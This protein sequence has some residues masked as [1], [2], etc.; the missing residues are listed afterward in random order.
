MKYKFFLTKE[1]KKDFKTLLKKYKSLAKDIKELQKEFKTNPNIGESLGDG[2]RKIRLNITSKRAGKSGGGRVISH[3]LIINIGTEEET[4]SIAFIALY[5]KSDYETADT[6][7]LKKMVKEIRGNIP[8]P[9]APIKNKT[10][11][12]EK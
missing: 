1:F 9:T 12:K 10:S 7:L 6:D 11:P 8:A 2:L 3:E 4:K 5:D